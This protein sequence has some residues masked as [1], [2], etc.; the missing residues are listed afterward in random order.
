M[1]WGPLPAP[2]FAV[3]VRHEESLNE[4]CGQFDGGELVK[5]FQVER[6]GMS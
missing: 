3:P 5:Y 6:K 4:G 1:F 2:N